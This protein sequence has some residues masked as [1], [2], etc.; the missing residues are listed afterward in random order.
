MDISIAVVIPYYNGSR[1][2]HETVASVLAQTMPAREVVI[3]DDGS[4]PE[5]S[6]AIQKYKGTI[7]IIRQ[8]N[9]GISAAR[10]IG[11]AQTSSEWVAFLDQ[12]DTWTDN[13]LSVLADYLSHHPECAA[14]HNAIQIHGSEEIYRKKPLTVSDFLLNADSPSQVMPSGAMVRRDIF[15]EAGMWDESVRIMEVFVFF[16]RVA[17]QST[18]HYVDEPLT[19][20]RLHEE[21][22]SRTIN[23]GMACLNKNIVLSHHRNLYLSERVFKKQI[24]SLNCEFLTRAF[25]GKDWKSALLTF[26]LAKEHGVSPLAL[27]ILGLSRLVKTKLGR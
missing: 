23:I 8:N 5:E 18:I 17:I 6:D 20:R 1:F 19:L 16:L 10:N 22:A 24:L 27:G 9:Q 15:H 7:L 21:N 13:R 12:D 25:Y 3:V 11:V 14:V 2:I 26:R 4:R